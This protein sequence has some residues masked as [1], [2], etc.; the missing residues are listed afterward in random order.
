MLWTTQTTAS[1]SLRRLRTVQV[2]DV[3]QSLKNSPR[4]RGKVIKSLARTWTHYDFPTTMIDN[5]GCDLAGSPLCIKPLGQQ[6]TYV[7]LLYIDYRLVF[8]TI[9]NSKIAIK[10]RELGLC[11]TLCKLDPQLPHQP[12]LNLPMILSLLDE[13]WV[14]LNHSIEIEN[15][16]EWCQKSILAPNVSKIKELIVDFIWWKL[17]IYKPIFIDS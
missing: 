2:F 6:G 9:I 1:C 11:S 10:L 4:Y 14:M 17:R 3:Q 13:C 16:I 15:Q 12:S 5:R 7:R 8:N